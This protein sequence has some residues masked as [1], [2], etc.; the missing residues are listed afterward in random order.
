MIIDSPI[1]SGSYA[2][3]GS[4]NQVGNVAISGSLTVTG[5][6]IG[7]LTGTASY[8][9]TAS[10][11]LNTTSASYAATAS[12][13]ANV[14]ETSSY[15]INA[16][17]A[18]YAANAT[19]ASYAANSTSA[20]YAVTASYSFTA[21]S[22]S[23]DQTASYATNIVISG[24]IANV[25]YIDFDLTASFA[26]ALG[27]LGY[28]SGEGTLQ[29]GLAGGNVTLNIGSDLFQYVYNAETSSLT[30]GQVVYVSGSQGNRIAVKLADDSADRVSASTLGFVAET[31]L[32]GGQGWVMTEGNLRKLN[33]TGLIGGKLLFL[34]STPGTYTQTVPVAPKHAV[35][36]GYAERIDNTVG[37]IYIKID[38]GYEIGELHDV[39][40]ST[41][42]S[43]YG[44]LFIKSGSVWI[45]SK[46]LTGSYG[47]TGSIT[48]TSLSATSLTASNALITNDL[49]VNGTASFNYVQTI[50]GSAVI[51]GQEYIILN[52]QTPAARY[53]G[54]KVYDSGS[55]ATASI[56]WDSLTNHWVY[57]NQSGSTYSGGGFL[58]G[59]R[60]T[61]S[62][63]DIIYPTQYKLLRSQG[64][65]HVY[66]SNII[67]NDTAV[68]IGINT[69]VTG[70]LIVTNGITSSL[71]GTAS[72]SNNT[73]SASYA[74]TAT[75]ADTASFVTTAQ[76]AS[77]VANAQTASYV[78]NAVSAS[79]AA[80]SSYAVNFNIS[81]SF[82]ASGLRYPTADNGSEAYLQTDGTGNLSFQYVKSMYETVRNR[83]TSSITAGTPLFVSGATGGNSDV[84]IADA[85]NPARMP[86]TYVASETI[87]SSGTG[88]ALIA[89]LLSNVNTSTYLAGQEIFVSTGSGITTSRPAYPSS[90]QLLGIV[91]KVGINGQVVILNP[92]Q[93]EIQNI[94]P[95]Y[96]LVGNSTGTPI[97]ISTSSL[98]VASASYSTYAVTSSYSLAGSGFPFSGS[99][100]IT[101]SLLVTNLSGTGSRYLVTDASGNITAQTAS[102]VIKTT[103]AYTATAGQTTFSVTNGYS[104]GYV[105]VFVN[106]S[107][108]NATEFTDTSGTNIVLATGSFVDDVVEVVKYLPASGVSN[109]VL[110][111]QTTFTASASQTVF[112]ASYTPGLLDIFYNGSKLSP[113]DFTANNGTY[114]TLATASAANDII[115]VFVYSYQVGAFS[116]IGGVGTASQI[117]YFNTSN[118][119]TGS[120]NFTISGSTMTV[121]G[122]LLVSGSGTFTNIGPAVFSGSI[123]ST[124]GFTGSF[125]GTATNATSAS[126]ALNATS[127][128][129]ALN[130]TTASHAITASSADDL[131]VRGT[132]TAQT[133]VVQTI[134]SS[135]DF[136]TGSTKFGSIISNTH[137]F[138][139]SVGISGSLTGT[140]ATFSGTSGAFIGI[141]IDNTDAAGSSRL[142]V[143]STGSNIT[144]VIS[145]SAS[146]PSRANQAW[147]GGDGSS[148]VTVLQAGGVEFL[149]GA[150][151]GAATFSSS[152]TATQFTSQGGR[153]T[154]YGYKLPDWQIYNTTSGNALAFSNYSTDLL[155]IASNGNT[156]IA[157]DLALTP[158]DSAITFSS[159]AGRFFTGGVERMRITSGGATIMYNN[160]AVVD[161]QEIYDTQTYAANTGGTINFGG[162]Y[163]SAGAYTLYARVSGR[164]ENSTDGN[165]AGYL[166]FTTKENGGGATERMRIT[167]GGVVGIKITPNSGWGSAMAALQMGTGGVL[168]NWTGAN[169]NFGLGVNYYDNGA[170][171]QLRLYTG[172]TSNISFNEDTITFS[173]AA[174]STAGSTITFVER[175]RI[176][177]GNVRIVNVGSQLQFDTDGSGGS[178]TL[179][180]N[181]QYDFRI[182]NGRGGASNI[183]VS[184]YEIGFGMNGST[185]RYRMGNSSFYPAGDNAYTC[186]ASGQRWSAIW[187]ANG[188]IQ[189]SDARQKKDITPTNLGLNF[190]MALNPVS[191]KWKVGKNVVTSDGERID[192]NGAKH[193]NDII[194]PVAGVR[195]HYG[196]IAQ[197]V[198][199]VLGDVD[200][201][202]YVHDEETDTLALRYDQFISPLIK[203]IQ[204]QQAQI[205]SL[206]A[207]INELKNK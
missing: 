204:E 142:R 171:S 19:S 207:E 112:S 55:N 83:E 156:S 88:K 160:M 28:D 67:D 133:I 29:F 107:K 176:S 95:G 7:N 37:S 175:M 50:T 120:P 180:T 72:F 45:N 84:Y 36:L 202:G 158:N 40:D 147:I 23:Y 58:A 52:T 21:V 123:T 181:G 69:E 122:S 114:F 134:T 195:T 9:T 51:I 64:D 177:G 110:R 152:V 75:T 85:S 162:K 97:A 185:N 49:A 199:E 94:Q 44:D 190:I 82:T 24:S 63:G 86:A 168:S 174:S 79:Y 104:T 183:D 139:G 20:S 14:P 155:T 42:S 31:I 201:G 106:G 103:Q 15:A 6:I 117:A 41:T 193:S 141:T 87:T 109:N 192:E 56:V 47:V 143:T 197:E 138:T 101:G 132:L 48:A 169:N 200:F 25:D 137:Q 60:N 159:G 170:G 129:Y 78:L 172:G 136:V 76:T 115:D 153:G 70:G 191:Y 3:T 92:G 113:D 32:A 146:H 102:A 62:L 53:A 108:L 93:I 179:G 18:S 77:F 73:T 184:T 163:N 125:S 5:S 161:G 105:D 100:V 140:S 196:L 35:R 128:S 96:T 2:G 16:L 90:V 66:D 121:T 10:Y 187:S 4:L 149:R 30:K 38:N 165:T 178:T 1:V 189:T 151:T 135:Q 81:Q 167:S 11:A 188:T 99:A 164:K 126:Y 111:Q 203:A 34:G 173:S 27:R 157:G 80:T 57:E 71:L 186:G 206:Q 98:S 144:D 145:Y 54:L 154:S 17:S 148:T 13:A 8:A 59:P 91:T 194:T 127:A 198:K 74:A 33:T 182:Y 65:D 46:Q 118:S 89:G 68:K 166:L 116:G 61:G 119:I 131:L 12:Y 39:V 26:S 124:A 205:Q 22:A 130:T 150:S 43:S